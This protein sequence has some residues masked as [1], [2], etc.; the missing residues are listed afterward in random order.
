MLHLN[1]LR[2]QKSWSD[3]LGGQSL[4]TPTLTPVCLCQYSLPAESTESKPGTLACNA[5]VLSQSYATTSTF[6]N[7]EK[8][9]KELSFVTF[10][11]VGSAMGAARYDNH[12]RM[13]A[14]QGS[15]FN[16]VTRCVCVTW[17]LGAPWRTIQIEVCISNAFCLFVCFVSKFDS[18]FG[19]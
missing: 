11:G 19:K 1:N 5:I 3:A 6:G 2:R 4:S 14:F 17:V 13:T 15:V 7:A 18:L 16:P 10:K 9:E 12:H 8:R